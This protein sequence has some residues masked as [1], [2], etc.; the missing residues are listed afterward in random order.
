MNVVMR[1]W[2]VATA[3][4]AVAACSCGRA[5]R[6][7]LGGRFSLEEPLTVSL[8]P[9][10]TARGHVTRVCAG[11]PAAYKVAPPFPM[12]NDRGKEVTI[13]ATLTTLEGRERRLGS[14]MYGSAS[15]GRWLVCAEDSTAV[16]GEVF[17]KVRVEGIPA[18][19]FDGLWIASVTPK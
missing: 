3:A 11:L 18:L 12:R 2:C 6:Q 16:R 7:I 19:E 1:R 10:F 9:P 8:S 15:D 14:W 17:A 13:V 4:L 5:D